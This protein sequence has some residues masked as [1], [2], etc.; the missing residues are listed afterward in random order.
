MVKRMLTLA[1]LCMCMT[2]VALAEE[3]STLNEMLNLES[4]VT[5]NK[6]REELAKTNPPESKIVNMPRLDLPPKKVVNPPMALAVYGVSPNYEGMM[7]FNGSVVTVKKG[8]TVFGKIVSDISTQ[9]ITL[10][11]P[12]PIKRAKHVK[13]K[14]HA[15]SRGPTTN[16]Y[17]VITR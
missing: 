10:V 1:G 5:V 6:M 4:K 11:T 8:S 3:A 7:D 13:R 15:T 17:P 12:A 16:F 14:K 2:Q 9:G